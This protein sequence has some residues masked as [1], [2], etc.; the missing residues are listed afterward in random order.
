M[1]QLY[2]VVATEPYPDGSGIEEVVLQPQVIWAKD[3][4]DALVKG[5]RLT[6]DCPDAKVVVRPF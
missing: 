1:G 6:S 5:G 4:D 3:S 2:W